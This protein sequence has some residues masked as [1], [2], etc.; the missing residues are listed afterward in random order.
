MS[1]TPTP[2][3]N[4]TPDCFNK[5]MRTDTETDSGSGDG[6]YTAFVT[7]LVNTNYLIKRCIMHTINDSLKG[8]SI[9]LF[10]YQP[11][12]VDFS[13]STVQN[14]AESCPSASRS[15]SV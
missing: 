6:N 1:N 7:M 9:F 10:F 12:D 11:A 14:S 4:D 3:K 13:A 8:S 15:K 5:W 2:S